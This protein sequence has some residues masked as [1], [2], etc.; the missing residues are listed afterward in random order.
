MQRCSCT[1]II[2]LLPLAIALPSCLASP[3]L[4]CASQCS[5]NISIFYRMAV[6]PTASH[7]AEPG[8]HAAVGVWP[9]SQIDY[10]PSVSGES[11]DNRVV[12]PLWDVH[13][14]RHVLRL[15]AELP[16]FVWPC[17]IHHSASTICHDM[18]SEEYITRSLSALLHKEAKDCRPYGL[19]LGGEG[20]RAYEQN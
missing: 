14:R 10:V 16:C 6:A 13:A 5:H 1:L 15:P 20:C 9:R 3:L 18:T 11:R 19:D 2:G 7:L 4:F 17:R 8:V 12:G